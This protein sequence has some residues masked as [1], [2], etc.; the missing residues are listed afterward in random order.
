MVYRLKKTQE[1]IALKNGGGSLA[2][3]SYLKRGSAPPPGGGGLYALSALSCSPKGML[4]ISARR[5]YVSGNADIEEI[6]HIPGT[7]LQR[8]LSDNGDDQPETRLS[9]RNELL[10]LKLVIKFKAF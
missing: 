5:T 1:R 4:S 2:F 9:I 8:L 6:G 3:G 10:T 7:R